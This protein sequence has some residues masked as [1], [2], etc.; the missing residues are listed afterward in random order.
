VLVYVAPSGARAGSAGT[1]ITLASN[2]AAMAP[3]TNIG[4][5]HPVTV[6]GKDPESEGGEH[7]AKKI[8]NDTL[9]FV[10][11]IA[12]QRGR[13]VEW[14]K[15]AVKESASITESK[16][17]QMKVVDFVARYV[18]DLLKQVDG[19]TVK[20]AGGET[21]L[22]TAASATVKMTLPMTL[23]MLN[24]LAAPTVMFVLILI[25]AL[26]I[27]VEFSHPGLIFPAVMSG[28]ACLLLLFAGRVLPMNLLGVGLL[29][30]GVALLIAEIYVTSF[31]LLTVGGLAAFF[32]G[33]LMLFDPS[34]TDLQ[35]PLGA[36]VAATASLGLISLAVGWLVVKSMLR[37]PVAGQ[38]ALVGAIASVVEVTAPGE[39]RVSLLGEYWNAR[40][41]DGKALVLGDRVRVKESENLILKVEKVS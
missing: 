35:V 9:A 36:V 14:A 25:F 29:V 21:T 2:I 22:R 4:A 26:G 7:M 28:I 38:G 15:Q 33:S 40:S 3:G 5:A 12:A 32:F 19:R 31:G 6:T 30:L 11:T 18:G 23:K 8:E 41:V 37:K 34:K 20:T 24:L 1:F 10:E 17:L 13:N 16:A 27:Y 39:L